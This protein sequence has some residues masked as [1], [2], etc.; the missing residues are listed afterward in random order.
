MADDLQACTADYTAHCAFRLLAC[1]E[2]VQVQ[3]SA[4]KVVT[5]QRGCCMP[6]VCLL[7]VHLAKL[8]AA[9]PSLDDLLTQLQQVTVIDSEL[10][11]EGDATG[12][13]AWVGPRALV[14]GSHNNATLRL[15]HVDEHQGLQPR[16][17]LTFTADPPG[18]LVSTDLPFALSSQA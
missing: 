3:S 11:V 8:A 6:A 4:G 2:A 9:G 5:C 17:T 10:P 15:W 14:T 18:T 13:V 16:H 1:S 7:Q 12:T